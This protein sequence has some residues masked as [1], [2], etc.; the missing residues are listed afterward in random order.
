MG[1]RGKC[2]ASAGLIWASLE[3][4]VLTRSVR[5]QVAPNLTYREDFKKRLAHRDNVR[6]RGSGAWWCKCGAICASL[7]HVWRM[8]FLMEQVWGNSISR[9]SKL[10]QIWC[11]YGTGLEKVLGFQCKF[12][13]SCGPTGQVAGKFV[14]GVDTKMLQLFHKKETVVVKQLNK[15]FKEFKLRGRIRSRCAT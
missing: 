7:G 6:S 10:A 14:W 1:L 9:W 12:G 13:A 2:G 3:E 8:F 11:N 5:K 15:C 4:Q